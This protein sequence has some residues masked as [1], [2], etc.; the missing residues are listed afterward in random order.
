[1]LK[2]R[3]RPMTAA[4]EYKD[5]KSYPTNFVHQDRMALFSPFFKVNPDDLGTKKNPKIIHTPY[6][7]IRFENGLLDQTHRDIWQILFTYFEEFGLQT[8]YDTDGNDLWSFTFTAYQLGKYLGI[9]DPPKEW[10]LKKLRE[11]KNVSFTLKPDKNDDLL[12]H[13]NYGQAYTSILHDVVFKDGKIFVS[14]SPFFLHCYVYDTAIYSRELTYKILSIQEGYLKAIVRHILT[15]QSYHNSLENLMEAVNLPKKSENPHEHNRYKRLITKPESINVLKDVTTTNLIKDD[16]ST[17]WRVDYDQ[18]NLNGQIWSSNRLTDLK[19][20]T[21]KHNNQQSN[22]SKHTIER[23]TKQ[24]VTKQQKLRYEE[25]CNKIKSNICLSS[26]E[27]EELF[28]L[29]ILLKII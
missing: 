4:K 23:S 18:K 3:K 7:E 2:L 19:K 17:K 6:G 8:G 21:F 14:V 27:D 28:T 29:K 11:M 16:I 10:I 12:K 24:F 9:K 20:K 25:L 13:F 22:L 26:K 5:V 15:H 1:M